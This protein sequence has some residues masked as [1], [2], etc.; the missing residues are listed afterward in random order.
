MKE[1]EDIA[2][3]YWR[4]CKAKVGYDS[5]FLMFIGFILFISLL[6]VDNPV[7]GI[8][9]YLYAIGYLFS[10]IYLKDINTLQGFGRKDPLRKL[11]SEIEKERQKILEAVLIKNDLTAQK[12]IQ[13]ALLEENVNKKFPS[14]AFNSDLNRIFKFI[15]NP[16]AKARIISLFIALSVLI[17][18]VLW[19]SLSTGEVAETISVV[20]VNYVTILK[21]LLVLILILIPLIL[22]IIYFYPVFIYLFIHLAGS[23]ETKKRHLIQ[24]CLKITPITSVMWCTLPK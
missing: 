24:A 7:L 14:L 4:K 8:V 9:L 15:Y 3:E 22:F 11:G 2:D 19:H 5:F 17:S 18:A 12:I 20:L 16:D 13:A 10:G 6:F 21:I 1:L 23:P